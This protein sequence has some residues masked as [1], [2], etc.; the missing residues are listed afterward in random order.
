MQGFLVQRS[1]TSSGVALHWLVRKRW[2]CTAGMDNYDKRCGYNQAQYEF[3]WK[4]RGLHDEKCQIARFVDLEF[5]F[6]SCVSCT[7]VSDFESG[8]EFCIIQFK[9]F[10]NFP[11]SMCKSSVYTVG[12]LTQYYKKRIL[13]DNFVSLVFLTLLTCKYHFCTRTT[14]FF[15]KYRASMVQIE[16]SRRDR[17]VQQV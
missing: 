6:Y 14:I 4:K 12:Q 1:F 15:F 2:F 8:C 5:Y 9:S 7:L 3:W 17:L 13:S 16:F 11:S 10:N